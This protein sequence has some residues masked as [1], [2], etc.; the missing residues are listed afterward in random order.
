MQNHP[1]NI[2]DLTKCTVAIRNSIGDH[3]LGTGVIVTDDGLIVTCYHVVGNI[4]TET[5]IDKTVGIYFPSAPE[6]K[7]YA[8]VLEE[9]SDSSLDI[10]FLQLQEKE[11][12]KQVAV[13]NLS[14]TIDST[15][16]FRSFGFRKEKTF[17]GLY[18]DGTIQGKVRKKFKGDSDNSNIT[19]QEVIQLN[20][21]GID[22]GMSG[23]PVL[24][25]KINRERQV[26]QESGPNK[27]DRSKSRKETLVNAKGYFL[28]LL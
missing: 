23:A 25:T 5:I 7:G 24:D 8:D 6:I 9:Y 27:I 17:D 10:A 20:S 3:I 12:P 21:D 26:L 11:L 15:H 2:E 1:A 13:A 16:T 4:K 19:L 18:S 28:W 22:H 14:E